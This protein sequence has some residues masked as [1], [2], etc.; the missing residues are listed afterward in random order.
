VIAD[1]KAADR[2]LADAQRPDL[3]QVLFEHQSICVHL[4]RSD[5]FQ[6]GIEFVQSCNHRLIFSR[7]TE[8]F[9]QADRSARQ[10]ASGRHPGIAAAEYGVTRQHD[11]PHSL[12]KSRGPAQWPLRV[13]IDEAMSDGFRLHEKIGN[14]AAVEIIRRANPE[15]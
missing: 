2:N 10:H 5:L 14:D 12:R 4:V 6:H 8:R 15:T 11:L 9:L 13:T 3:A 7:R 1:P